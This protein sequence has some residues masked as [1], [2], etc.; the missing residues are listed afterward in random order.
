MIDY[1]KD[2]WATIWPA[3]AA[4]GVILAFV[5]ILG[6]YMTFIERKLAA[7]VQDRLGPNRVGPFGLF[8]A[9]ADGIKIFLKEQVIPD[10]VYTYLY[11]IAPSFSLMTAMFALV[12]MPFGPVPADYWKGFRFMVAP[13]IDIGIMMM[14]AISS[15]SAYGIILGGWASNNKYSLYGAIR[16]CAQFI[17]YEIPLG[18]SIIGIIAATSSLN[19]EQIVAAQGGSILNW[20]VVWQPLAMIIFFTSAL[21]ETNRLPF[22]LPECEQELVGGFH[23][24]YGGIKFVLFF[25]AE[26]THV[27]TVSFLTVL[28]F[29]G[30]WHMPGLTARVDASIAYM[31]LYTAILLAK[32]GLVV[33]FIMLLRWALPRFRFDQLMGMAWK[34]LIPLGIVNLVCVAVVLTLGLPKHLLCFTAFFLVIGAMISARNLQYTINRPRS[35]GREAVAAYGSEV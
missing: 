21:A 23:T 28:L 2:N 4:I 13:G 35:A 15:L 19:I 18:L 10:H 25:L 12:V 7:Y 11:F 1:I 31:A 9:I 24:E 5:P 29:F 8:Q 14:I 27:V 33:A 20:N 34:G 16:S 32:V 22:D 3:L 30:G 26:Y 17:S 6:L